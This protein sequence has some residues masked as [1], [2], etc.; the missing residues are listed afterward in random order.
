M[1]KKVLGGKVSEELEIPSHGVK[2]VFVDLGN[3]KIELLEPLGEKSPISKFLEK[4]P[5]GGM[6]HICVE[7]NDI[8]SAC[9]K[10]KSEGKRVLGDVS[11]GAHGLPV[12]FIHPKDMGGVLIE[13]E[14]VKSWLFSSLIFV[15]K[16]T[17]EKAT[18]INWYILNWMLW[19]TTPFPKGWNAFRLARERVLFKLTIGE[20]TVKGSIP[21][22]FA[23]FPSHVF[24]IS[25]SFFR[26]SLSD[27]V[28][29]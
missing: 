3:T 14:E 8:N 19:I 25:F 10:L 12:V 9:E 29:P 26:E 27:E 16:A 21:S 7:V 28:P 2:T 18:R 5:S 4:S 15:K 1:Y 13:L 20:Y 11:I 23:T 6:H 24:F 17:Y 22:A